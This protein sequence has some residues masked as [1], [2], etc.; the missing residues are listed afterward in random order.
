MRNHPMLR[1]CAAAALLVVIF[2]LGAALAAR[3]FL[4]APRS[5]GTPPLVGGCAA[6]TIF[7]HNAR[8][9]SLMAAGGAVSGGLLSLIY[10]GTAGY[11]FGDVVGSAYIRGLPA[12]R[13]AALIVPHFLIEFPGMVLGGLAGMKGAA[14]LY[15]LLKGSVE[16]IVRTCRM[17]VLLWASAL[18]LLACSA[19]VECWYTLAR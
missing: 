4:G 16:G 10:T 17:A 5:Q 2:C 14:L 15:H 13:L 12:R 18:A 3:P 19:G 7:L 8:V 1:S 6:Q 9:V 11:S